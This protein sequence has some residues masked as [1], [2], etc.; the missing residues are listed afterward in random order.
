MPAGASRFGSTWAVR[1]GRYQRSGMS[2]CHRGSPVLHA[3]LA[4]HGT[5]VP[6]D[7]ARTE[8]E[9]LRD[10][11]VGAPSRDEVQHLLLPGR[12]VGIHHPAIRRGGG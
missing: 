5:N 8:A 9:R 2:R 11:A 3:K 6:V 10:L 4:Q 12:Q 7:G 1:Y